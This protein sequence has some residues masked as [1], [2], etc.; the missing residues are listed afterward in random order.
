MNFLK[1]VVSK[2][3][4]GAV[5][6]ILT[7]LAWIYKYSVRY[8]WSILWYIVLGIFGVVMTYGAGILSKYI[9]D[10]V[11]G[12]DSKLLITLGV[13]YA[14]TQIG[15]IIFNAFANRVSAKISLKVDLEIRSDIYKKIMDAD[16]EEM[17]KYHSGDLL[18]RI[19]ND[20]SVV[21][22]G[23]LGWMP[24]FLTAVFRF[25]GAFGIILY[26]DSVLAIISLISAPVMLLISRTTMKKMREYIK[27]SREASTGVM[28]FNEESF[29]NLQ[30][31]KS[32]GITDYYK[33][34]LVS[35]QEV[36]RDV[37]LKH[38]KFSIKN[39]T[40]MS[41]TGMV[42]ATFCFG[43]AVYRLWSGDITYGTMTLFLQMS[44][45]LSSS[46]TNLVRTIPSAIS[47]ATAAGR[48]MAIAEL[49]KEN[50]DDDEKAE[51]MLR[52]NRKSGV[53]VRSFEMGFVYSD[54]KRV[55]K[56]VDFVANPGEIIAVVGSSGG[57]K[58][59][60]LRLLLGIVHP[61][62]GGIEIRTS[63]GEK[64]SVS[65]S[66]RCMFAYV[67]QENTLF[68]GT[69]AENLRLLNRDATDDELHA[70]LKIACADE[71]INKLPDGINAPVLESG[72]GFSEGQIQRLSIARA[73]LA[74][75]PVLLFDEATSALDSETEKRLLK[76]IVE[77]EK[78]KTCIITTHRPGVLSICDKVY[79]ITD[80]EMKSEKA[81][82]VRKEMIGL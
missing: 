50:R 22:S 19:D 49:P 81:D 31:I 73:I 48:V 35:V 47:S 26:Y 44:A 60:M 25:V 18:N 29:H 56:N 72:T 6:E 32:F 41:A 65:A 66:T 71:F 62:E 58:T 54:D 3:K 7:E 52:E 43:W 64:L 80:G 16:W 23:V 69:V 15:K 1:K 37:Q 59:T 77:S 42:V 55:F 20:V 30:V 63:K 10:A 14:L 78:G 53:T 61:K 38:N 24:N 11:T 68:A 17:S 21:S 4:E 39:S 51:K 8:K 82:D 28:V 67:P 46:F 2:I 40:I 75:V 5:R 36:Y 70:A 33:E 57:G 45:A 74:D 27:K 12:K 76:N 79:R 34:K 9:V 13:F